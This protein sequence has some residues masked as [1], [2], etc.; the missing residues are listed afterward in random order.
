MSSSE[1]NKAARVLV[2][3]AGIV[4]AGGIWLLVSGTGAA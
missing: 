2:L 4:L 1:L 3:A